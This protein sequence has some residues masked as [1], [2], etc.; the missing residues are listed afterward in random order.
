MIGRARHLHD[1]RLFD[2]YV[3][4]HQGDAVDPPAAEHL[5]DCDACSSRYADLARFMETIRA[6]GQDE[7]DAIFTADRLRLQH[8]QIVR[9]LET[10]YST[11]VWSSDGSRVTKSR[12]A[13]GYKACSIFLRTRS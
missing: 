6:E 7:A 13:R 11:L 3:A 10:T 4:E 1:D 2:C 8:Q 12:P 9:R 5:A